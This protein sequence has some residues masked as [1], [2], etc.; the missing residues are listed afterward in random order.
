LYSFVLT[1]GLIAI[2]VIHTKVKRHSGINLMRQ[3]Q[4]NI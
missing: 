3:D 2:L 1:D 4:V